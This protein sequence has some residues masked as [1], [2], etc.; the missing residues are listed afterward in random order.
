MLIMKKIIFILLFSFSFSF[1]TF[2]SDL[3]AQEIFEFESV[4]GPKEEIPKELVEKYKK[5]QEKLPFPISFER[6][7]SEK[8]IAEKKRGNFVTGL[9]RMERNPINGVGAGGEM[10]FYI[11]G[12]ESDPF[13]NYTPYR[14]KYLINLMAYENGKLFGA[15]GVDLPF[16]FDKKWRA[17]FDVEYIEER[18]NPLL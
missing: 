9:P 5:E 3:Y 8:D 13:F 17:R 18:I 12:D 6:R 2:V 11:N 4:D 7:L 10:F 15:F 1:V 16:W 14:Q